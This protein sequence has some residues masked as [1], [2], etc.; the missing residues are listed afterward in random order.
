M[1]Y[2]TP[3]TANNSIQH[4]GVQYILD[5]VVQALAKDKE[6]TFIYVEIAFFTRWWREQSNYTKNLVR[7][8]YQL[9][10]KSGQIL[11]GNKASFLKSG[12]KYNN[13]ILPVCNPTNIKLN[14]EYYHNILTLD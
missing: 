2:C 3:H 13:S 10:L 14:R 7:I 1:R 8:N 9:I 6:K 4:A 11:H 12:H 5:S